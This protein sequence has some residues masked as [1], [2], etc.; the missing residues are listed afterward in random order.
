MPKKEGELYKS[1]TL[2]GKSFD[3]YYGFYEPCDR[4]SPLCEA[5]PIYPD[6]KAKPIYTDEGYPFVTEIEDACEHFSGEGAKTAD[7]T[8]GEC[9][10]LKKGEE[11]IGICTRRKTT[12]YNK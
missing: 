7:S 11:W 5:V 4:E 6:F 1:F 12:V 2:Y 3:I 10:H 9:R 8:C